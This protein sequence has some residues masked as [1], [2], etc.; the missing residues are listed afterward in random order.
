MKPELHVARFFQNLKSIFC[1]FQKT[2]KIIHDVD[3]VYIYKCVKFELKS[4]CILGYTKK[5]NQANFQKFELCTVHHPDPPI[6]HFCP[7]QNTTNLELKFFTLVDIIITNIW[8]FFVDFWKRKNTHFQ[9]FE[10]SS[11]SS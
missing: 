7:A 10:V 9:F 8:D 4:R 6:C 3:N 11:S 2:V 5:T 1:I